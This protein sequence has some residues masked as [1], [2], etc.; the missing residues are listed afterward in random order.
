V[1]LQIA[2]MNPL[3][4]SEDQ[5]PADLL[6]KERAVRLEQAKASGKPESIIAK[7]VEGQ[8]AKWKQEV[9]LL[10]QA[11]VKDDKK[12]IED[13]RKGLVAKIGE[14]CQIRR[15][16]RFEVGEGLDKKKDDFA[17]EVRKQAGL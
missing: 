3:C 16:V 9:V 13:L 15:F 6:E 5:L 8:I 1:S 4:I 17:Q 14:N 11:W 10:H 2:A 7:M 12:T